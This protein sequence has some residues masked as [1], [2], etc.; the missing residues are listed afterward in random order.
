M[1]KD[2]DHRRRWVEQEKQYNE[3]WDKYLHDIN[4]KELALLVSTTNTRLPVSVHRV[5]AWVANRSS[6]FGLNTCIKTI[7][8]YRD[9]LVRE[10]EKNIDNGIWLDVD[11][12]AHVGQ[13]RFDRKM[14]LSSNKAYSS[15]SSEFPHRD[16][17]EM[18]TV[19]M[20]D[21]YAGHEGDCCDYCAKDTCLKL[22]VH[23]L[24][25]HTTVAGVRV[26]DPHLCDVK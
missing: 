26:F 14:Y 12:T 18:I 15:W 13:I 21:K 6:L 17:G 24:E 10:L 16:T 20:L 9:L 23:E 22:L 8:V 5:A 3:Y 7:R 19:S 1:D 25:E 11:L 2:I 4:P